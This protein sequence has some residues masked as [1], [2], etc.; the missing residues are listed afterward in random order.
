MKKQ[1]KQYIKKLLNNK[2]FISWILFPT[3]DTDTYW[4]DEMQ[5]E[6]D[7]AEEIQSLKQVL[8]NM[9]VKE[10]SLSAVDQNE[11]WEEIKCNTINKEKKTSKARLLFA[12]IAASVAVLVVGYLV[13]TVQEPVAPINYQ[14][15]I[16][17]TSDESS[18]DIELI[19]SG[20]KVINIE[21]DSVTLV[22]DAQGG[23]TMNANNINDEPSTEINQ[24]TVPYGKS[25]TIVLSDGS[26]VY[27][28]SGSKLLYPAVFDKHK[29][30]IYVDG[31]IYLDV[32]K[33]KD[34]PFVVKTSQLEVN[35]L[36]TS[37]NVKA[38]SGAQQQEI[39]LVEGL[40]SV[41]S[42]TA[43]KKQNIQPNQ[44]YSYNSESNTTSVESIDATSYVAWIHGYILCDKTPLDEILLKLRRYYNVDLTYDSIAM[45][46][47]RVTGK[48]DLK[49][50]IE[51]VLT[52]IQMIAPVKCRMEY[53]KYIINR[54]DK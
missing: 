10:P 14:A 17:E 22:Y 19:L 21:E 28:N 47:T 52:Y 24:L 4:L 45:K 44:I 5:N 3:K 33:D 37:F 11:V 20:D 41:N 31:E 8:E 29:R 43:R 2:K 6:P 53:E 46:N 9:A 38:Y 35:V 39:V 12:S 40:V 15:Y 49:A 32:T 30:E 34:R 23:V 13:Y 36:G 54:T 51:E 25:S 1:S 26:K 16:D 50:G 42:A 7:K 27:I 18:T 48:L